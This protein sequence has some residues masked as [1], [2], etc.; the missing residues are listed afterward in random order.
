MCETC[1]KHHNIQKSIRTHKL[2]DISV[3]I[4]AL[5]AKVTNNQKCC[6]L[7][8]SNEKSIPACYFCA[9]CE[10]EVLC[11]TCGKHHTLQK[12][13]KRHKL[14]DIRQYVVVANPDIIKN[15]KLCELCKAN[16]KPIPAS[17]FCADC[18]NEFL[19]ET[20]G[21]HHNIQKSTKKHTLKDISQ[22]VD[23][24]NSEIIAKLLLCEF[25]TQQTRNLALRA[26]FVP[27]V[28]MNFFVRDAVNF[29][30]YKSQLKR[31]HCK[32]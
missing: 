25:C 1:G 20:C 9:E 14:Q 26:T 5:N 29:T 28:K 24:P 3:H 21:K 19:C 10:N 4:E 7:C 13:T 12:S 31:T 18:D 32:I 11:E 30:K 8:T 27:N 2:Q 17:Y 23:V 6:E 16:G 15:Q 22:Y